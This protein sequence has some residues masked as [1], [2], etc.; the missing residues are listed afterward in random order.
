MT[1]DLIARDVLLYSAQAALVIAAGAGAA[2]LLRLREPNTMLTFWSALLL[3]CVFLPA[4]QPWHAA[5][6]PTAFESSATATAT[7]TAVPAPAVPSQWPLNLLVLTMLAA[8]IV[9]RGLWLLI[10]A[11]G[12]RRL[13]KSAA[14][15]TPIPGAMRAAE[16][17]VGAQAELRVSPRV[18]GP[19]TFG[20]RAP[21]IVVPPAVLALDERVQ[22]A[23]VCHELLHVRRHDWLHQIVE[24]A[25]RTIFWFHPVVRWLIGRIQ[26]TREEV[27][28]REAIDLTRSRDRYIDALMAVALTQPRTPLF[29]PAP[30]FLRRRSLKHRINSLFE[31]SSMSTRRLMLSLAACVSV[32]ALAAVVSV[33]ALPLEA[34]P[35]TPAQ[36]VQI[37]A[38]GDHLLHASLPEY[39]RAAI[40]NH[41]EGD[42]VLQ[43]GVDAQGN[44]IDAR[45]INGPDELRKVALRAALDWHFSPASVKST[46]T[47]ATIRFTLPP[48]GTYTFEGRTV[49]YDGFSVEGW[50]GQT[51]QAQNLERFI[52]EAKKALEDPGV[53]GEKRAGIERKL[54]EAN[55]QL[56]AI[57]AERQKSGEATTVEMRGADGR[58][59]GV[60]TLTQ[61]RS[62]RVADAALKDFIA[63]LGV[64]IGDQ[65][66]E[67][68]AREIREK[69]AQI[70]QH[71]RVGFSNDGKNGLVLTVIAP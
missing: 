29:V 34:Q 42:V 70:D 37:V 43:L 45:V 1:A 57:R 23:I 41:I 26:L 22:E 51:S 33:R 13:R 4:L 3:T 5:P 20:A 2:R 69:A 7:L 55:S 59:E 44:V 68:A 12:L 48:A 24:E 31:E 67:S 6:L 60:R 14:L 65:I 35:G 19:I 58:I 27:V 32:F 39:P 71:L 63:Q 64:K 21:V 38:G 47:Q 17:S 49:E 30:L 28:D 9:V 61:I 56:E 66:T 25:L 36:P 8:G 50:K 15:L 46:L 54:A 11:I 53:T 18:A 40:E 52:D 62:E 16:A 10:T